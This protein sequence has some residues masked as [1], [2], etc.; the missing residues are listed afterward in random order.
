MLFH[1]RLCRRHTEGRFKKVIQDRIE[2]FRVG[3]R[4]K[5]RIARQNRQLRLFDIVEYFKRMFPPD[6][7]PIPRHDQYRRRNLMQALDLDIRLGFQQ[8]QQLLLKRPVPRRIFT[9]DLSFDILLRLS[10]NRLDPPLNR[11]VIGP[12]IR[13][14]SANLA[15]LSG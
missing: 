9:G 6:H 5:M 15:T 1:D 8:S 13:P 14:H 2:F 10:Q 3:N 12:E 4:R 7:I 11:R